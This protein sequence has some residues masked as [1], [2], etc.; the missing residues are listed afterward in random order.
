M[1][2][3]YSVTFTGFDTEEQARVFAQQYEG[4]GEQD[5]SWLEE[6]TDLDNAPVDRDK[7]DY[8]FPAVNGVIEVPLKMIYKE[9][10]HQNYND[11]DLIS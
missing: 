3:K 7:V 11:S 9:T 5:N 10:T 8:A 1:E 4:S 2:K 6:H